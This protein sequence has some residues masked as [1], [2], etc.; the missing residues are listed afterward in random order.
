VTPDIFYG[1]TDL[2]VS[3]N[4]ESELKIIKKKISK[5]EIDF[6][7]IK[8]YSSPLKRCLKLAKSISKDIK[9]DQRLKELH[10]GDWEMKSRE[11][12][13]KNMIEEWENNLMSFK[14]PNGESNTEFLARLGNFCKDIL[15]S[16]NDSF[17]VAHAGSINGMISV[18][19]GKPFDELVENYWEKISYGSLSLLESFNGK[20]EIQFIGK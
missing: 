4:F 11:S 5:Y 6:K 17:V 9:L 7:K 12:I 19:T 15:L 13:P 3:E 18:L 10:L 20:T 2:D 14:I 16:N 1:Q 8:F